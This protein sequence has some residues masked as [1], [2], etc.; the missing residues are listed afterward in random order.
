MEKEIKKITVET[1][2]N[3]YSLKFDGMKSKS[4]FMYFTPEGLLH[5]FM[6]H[7]GLG[8]TDQLAME[9]IVDFIDATIKLSGNASNVKE[10]RL[11]KAELNVAKNAR[12]SMYSKLKRERER[13][14][15]LCE[16]INR[17]AE[18]YKEIDSLRKALDGIVKP[19]KRLEPFSNMPAN[20]ERSDDNE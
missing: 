17:I 10:L 12:A 6:C 20:E 8:M 3:G 4:G 15:H 13:V 14:I 18:K 11:M 19:Y 5:G 2:P 16:E 7:I 9:N 1:L